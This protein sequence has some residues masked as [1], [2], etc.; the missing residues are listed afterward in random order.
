MLHFTVINLCI[1]VANLLHHK[2]NPSNELDRNR[3]GSI[4]SRATAGGK[5]GALEPQLQSATSIL[6]TRELGYGMGPNARQP[7]SM[8]YTVK[9]ISGAHGS[10]SGLGNS[11]SIPSVLLSCISSSVHSLGHLLPTA[12]KLRMAKECCAGVMYLHSK[13]IMHCDIK[14][15]NFL[16]TANLNIKLADLGEARFFNDTDPRKLPRYISLVRSIFTTL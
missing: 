3:I 1:F 15:L 16:V 5:R 4:A 12:I 7:S 14:S 13:S 10:I 11:R 8:N 6:L 2:K 9:S